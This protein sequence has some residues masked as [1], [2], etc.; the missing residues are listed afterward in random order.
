VI[1]LD[2]LSKVLP[3]LLLFILGALFRRRRFLSEAAVADMKKLVVNVTLPAV[4]FLAFAGVTLEPRHLILVVVVFALCVLALWASRLLGP[5][6]GLGSRYFPPLATGFEAGMMGYAIYAAVYGQENIF[7]FAVVDLGQVLFV[8]FILVPYISQVATGRTSASETV[9]GFLKTPVILSIFLGIVFNQLALVEPLQNWPPTDA[10]FRTLEVIGAVTTPLIAIVI[11][12]ELRLSR[13]ALSLPVRAIGL[14]LLLW[15]PAG[16][17]VVAL[18]VD[19]VLR[20][21]PLFR[22]AVMTMFVLPPPFVAPLFMGKASEEER[23]FV[24]NSLSLATLLTLVLFTIVTVAY[25]A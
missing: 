21:D 15:I 25:P 11:G 23:T 7:R 19:G 13:G 24:V 18:I 1:Y 14:R 6:L 9:L 10:V 12:Y 16:L 2:A 4:L 3:V 17:L 20:G 8:F 22:A 5:P